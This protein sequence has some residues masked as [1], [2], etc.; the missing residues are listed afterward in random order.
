MKREFSAD[1]GSHR[2][3]PVA[4]QSCACARYPMLLQTVLLAALGLSHHAWPAGCY[5]QAT[6][7]AAGV[8]PA[9]TAMVAMEDGVR[10]ATD[11]YLPAKGDPPFAVILIRTPYGKDA[12]RAL[13]PNFGAMGY[14]V[15]AQD[16]RGRFA[17]EGHHAIIFGNDGPGG[18]HRDGHDTIRWITRQTWSNGKV[19]TWGGS[20]LGIVQNMTAPD[21]PEALKGQIVLVGF[22]DYYLQGA[23]Q[24]GAWRTELIE[25]WL[26]G[27][28]ND[29]ITLP[30]FLEHSTY[31]A[32]WRLLNAEAHADHVN[33]PG[34]FIGG[35]YDIFLQGTINSFITIQERGGPKA[36]GKCFLVIGPA[37]HGE[38][39][40]KVIYPHAKESPI[41]VVVQKS[42]LAHWLKSE[43]DDVRRLKPVHYYVMGDLY[44]KN[45]PGNFWRSADAWPPS[46]Q[47]TAYYFHADHALGKAPPEGDGK[48][49]YKYDPINPV[50]TKGGQNL[51]IEKGPMDQRPVETR[52]DVLLFTTAPLIQPVEVTGRIT[53]KIYISSDCTDTDF[54]VKVCDVYPDGKSMLV[55]D[56]IRRA[57]L[58]KSFEKREMLEPG[59]VYELDVDVWS[60]SLVFNAGHRIRVAVSSSNSP[61]FEPNPNTGAPHPVSGETRVATNT[62]HL[63]AQHPSRIVLPIYNG[64]ESKGRGE[65]R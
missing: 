28:K 20:A 6:R 12:V 60:T 32:F 56:G 44:D 36:R 3:A 27:T 31:D 50:P 54:T 64:P 1:L 7:V 18:R 47:S 34:V 51:T 11:I 15:V 22:S 25:R 41:D 14:V 48:L 33:A 43:Q 13:A 5:A 35:W 63:S 62:L 23:Y 10:L 45:A 26:K 49:T 16:M 19:A 38:F 9:Q 55:T 8:A 58:R 2:Q 57:S 24:G 53:A 21:A 4:E 59:K 52:P 30:T 65:R 40:E 39:T 37:A 46:T 17:S 29:D 61:R 42:V